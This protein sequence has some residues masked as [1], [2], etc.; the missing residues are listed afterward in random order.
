VNGSYKSNS[1]GPNKNVIVSEAYV[2]E[3]QQA[4]QALEAKVCDSH[5][6]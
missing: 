3:A 6:H 2:Q 5:V 4:E 1:F